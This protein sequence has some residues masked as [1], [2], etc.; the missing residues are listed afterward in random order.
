V[1]LTCVIHLS[2]HLIIGST[3]PTY[4]ITPAAVTRYLPQFLIGFFFIAAAYIKAT[5]GLF[6]ANQSELGWILGVWKTNNFMPPFYYGFAD[7]VLT[8][9]ATFFAILVIVLQGLTGVLLIGNKH[10]RLAGALLFFV[11]LNIFLAVNNQLELRVFNG[12]AMLMG[13]YFFAGSEAR[14][15][16]WSLM[17]LLLV[18]I[19]LTHLYGRYYYFG[20]AWPAAYFWQRRHFSEFIMSAWP[21]LKYFTLWVTSGTSGPYIWAAAWWIKL[22]LVL[23]LLT[24]YR[25]QCGIAWLC[26]MILITMIWLNAF[27]CEGVFWVLTLFLWVIHEHDLQQEKRQ[28]T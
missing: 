27:S 16:V 25:L 5:E 4:K 12:Q 11:N 14:G 7:H 24:R 22:V 21:G 9:Y 19:G 3:M 23:G 17:T 26:F 8:P 13:V 28:A 18:L 2:L 20:D 10:V 15:R 1:M 6:G